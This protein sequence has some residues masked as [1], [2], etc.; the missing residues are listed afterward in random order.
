MNEAA[1]A[2]G[3]QVAT[4]EHIDLAM[5]KGTNYPQ[6]PLAWIDRIGTRTVRGV[7]AAF[8]GTVGDNRYEPAA[9][10]V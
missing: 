5:I 7:L 4:A 3:E 1:F 9:L 6:G 2:L 10:F 8:N